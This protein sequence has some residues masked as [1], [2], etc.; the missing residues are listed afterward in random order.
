[1]SER[2]AALGYP[3]RDADLRELTGY[4]IMPF[5]KADEQEVL[6]GIVN[7]SVEQHFTVSEQMEASDFRVEMRMATYMRENQGILRLEVVQGSKI[8]PF[9]IHKAAIVDNDW[10]GVDVCGHGL[11]QGEAVIRITD[12]D[13]D[14]DQCVTIY[15]VDTE[16]LGEL[17]FQGTKNDRKLNLR[18][19]ELKPSGGKS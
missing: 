3:V 17:Y 11:H 8:L 12:P 16:Q 5:A 15:T 10:F 14:S 19:K 13:N 4:F 2:L 7:G 9:T 1:M 6:G 18:I